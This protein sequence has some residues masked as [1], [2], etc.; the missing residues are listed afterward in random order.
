MKN[1]A[2]GPIYEC[3][4][5]RMFLTLKDT[6]K[7]TYSNYESRRTE[8][9]PWNHP[10]GEHLAGRSFVGLRERHLIDIIVSPRGKHTSTT[11]RNNPDGVVPSLHAACRERV[12]HED[13]NE[14]D[15]DPRVGRGEEHFEWE[16]EV[17]KPESCDESR[18]RQTSE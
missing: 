18:D 17:G 16:V 15:E 8:K 10:A 9:R 14:Y 5:L 4:W 11:D 2:V 1:F 13:W 12:N 6:K 3:F 7:T